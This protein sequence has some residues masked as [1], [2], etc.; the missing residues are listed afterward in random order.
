VV[1]VPEGVDLR[2]V[3]LSIELQILAFHEQ[4]KAADGHKPRGARTV[5]RALREDPVNPDPDADPAPAPRRPAEPPIRQR[6]AS[7]LNEVLP[8]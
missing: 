8:A 1:T 7:D 6:S 3:D 4:R 5:R 2:K